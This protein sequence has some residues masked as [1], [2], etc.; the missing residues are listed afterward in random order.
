ML[1]KSVVKVGGRVGTLKTIGNEL[2]RGSLPIP[3]MYGI[4]TYIWLICM[5]NVGKYIPYMDCL[6]Y[7]TNPNYALLEG[8]VSNVIQ[9]VNCLIPPQIRV[10]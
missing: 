8:H 10:I 3:S 9:F 5:V 6:G 7:I 1:A 2:N 4:F